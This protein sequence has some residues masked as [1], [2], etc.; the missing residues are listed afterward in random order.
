MQSNGKFEVHVKPGPDFVL[1][2]TFTNI[3]EATKECQRFK[4]AKIVDPRHDNI[5]Y[6]RD[7]ESGEEMYSIQMY[8]ETLIF[9]QNMAIYDSSKII[10]DNNKNNTNV[11]YGGLVFLSFI[12]V[13]SFF[14]NIFLLVKVFLY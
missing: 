12:S 6:F 3:I 5:L 9:L 14:M 8:L 11:L 1:H 13:L 4:T 2:K 10:L 7:K